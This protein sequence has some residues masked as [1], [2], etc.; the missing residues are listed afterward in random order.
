MTIGIII[1]LN[2]GTLLK[3]VQKY[4]LV[5]NLLNNN[6]TSIVSDPRNLQR[7]HGHQMRLPKVK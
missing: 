5:D 3:Q 6:L 1:L 7:N 4:T 2:I